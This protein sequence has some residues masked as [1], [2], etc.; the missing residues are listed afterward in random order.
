MAT[1]KI[2]SRR[3]YELHVKSTVAKMQISGKHKAVIRKLAMQ[4]FDDGVAM[5]MNNLKVEVTE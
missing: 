2:E 5:N 4:C 3:E 1:V